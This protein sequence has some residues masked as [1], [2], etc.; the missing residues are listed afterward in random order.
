MPSF[1][2][3]CVFRTDRDAGS[4]ADRLI[5]LRPYLLVAVAGYAAAMLSL[6]RCYI[7]PTALMLA[8]ATAYRNVRGAGRCGMVSLR[9][10]DGVSARR[11]RRGDAPRPQAVHP[12]V[13]PVRLM[14]RP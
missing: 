8:L 6:S 11:S 2:R 12:D 14:C 10:G 13:R 9:S 7:V 1:S 5:R 3:C 4:D